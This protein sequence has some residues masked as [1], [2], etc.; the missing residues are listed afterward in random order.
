MVITIQPEVFSILIVTGLLICVVLYAGMKIKQ[1]DPGQAPK[2]IVV[3]A[4]YLIE[5]ADKFT[6]DNMGQQFV[7]SFGPYIGTIAMYIFCC[8]ISGLFGLPA[9]TSNLSVTLALGLISWCIIQGVSLKSNKLS[10]YVKGLLEPFAVMLPVNIFGKIA[11]LVSMSMRL[12]G[13]ILVGGVLMSLVYSATGLLANLIFAN[14]KFNFIGPIIAP[15]LHGYFDLFAGFIQMFIF[16][17]VT[18]VLAGNEV[19]E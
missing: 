3:L 17:S 14:C 11:P 5:W 2:G 7:K 18:T 19:S 15:V 8:N 6:G 16:I 1:S 10:G 9:P 12:F 4:L 13:N